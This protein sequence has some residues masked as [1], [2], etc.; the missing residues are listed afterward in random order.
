MGSIHSPAH[1]LELDL[2]LDPMQRIELLTALEQQ[3][4]GDVPESRLAEIYSVRELVDA[5]LASA[6]ARVK[7]KRQRLRLVDNSQPSRPPIPKCLRWHTITF[8]PKFSSSCSARFIY[9][10]ALDRFH[11]KS[12]DSKIFPK[13]VPSCF[14]PITKATL[15]HC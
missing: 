6:M 13:K 3:L 8:L 4:G 1:N 12:A 10:F 5:V 11:L 7:P 14:V 9:L 15:I 2:G